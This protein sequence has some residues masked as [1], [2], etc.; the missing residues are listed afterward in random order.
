MR[1]QAF[2]RAAGAAAFALVLWQCGGGDSKQSRTASAARAGRVEACELVPKSEMETILGASVASA[3]G[4][5]SEH[6]YTTPP[7]YTASC[8]YMGERA[9]MLAVN[10]PATSGQASSEQLGAR[11]TEQLRS[12]VGSDPST[13]ELFRSIQ[14]R[15]V[16]GL[17]GLA[18]EYEMLDQTTLEVH[19]GDHVL[20]VTSP[21]LDDARRIATTAIE[22]LD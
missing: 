10:Y 4:N 8:M 6:T 1:T 13:D 9:V 11:V 14:V 5:F 21:S 20:K 16:A 18:A 22:R 3:K 12:Q 15:P 2:G 17:A 7:S 19:S